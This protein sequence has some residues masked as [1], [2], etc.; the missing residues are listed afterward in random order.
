MTYFDPPKP[1]PKHEC[2]LPN[3]D[4]FGTPDG[5][6]CECG[7]AYVKESWWQHGESGH[8]WRRSP[9]NDQPAS[10]EIPAP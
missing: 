9:E 10:G 2:K 5:W 8:N 7:K 4:T 6:R 3:P 1:K